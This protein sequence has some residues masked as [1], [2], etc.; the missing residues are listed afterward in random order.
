MEKTKFNGMLLLDL[1]KAFDTV[2]H[3]ILL[4]KLNQYGIRGVVNNFFESYLT[5]R[6]QGVIFHDNDLS[7]SNTHIDVP[8]GSSLG[9]LLFLLYKND[10]PNC[11]SSTL[12]LFADDTFILVKANTSIE[13]EFLLNSELAKCNCWIV[14]YELTLNAAKSSAIVIKPK[15][16]SPPVEMNLSCAAGSI[17]V[18]SS[19]KYLDVF[20]DDKLNF[21][22]RIKHL[23]KKV[24]RSVGILSKLK[25]YLPKHALFK[26][27]YM[28]VHSNL[29]H[30]LIVWGNTHPIYL[31]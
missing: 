9:P 23:E 29:L 25:N 18:V 20:I 16:H 12:R 3:K 24:S 8:Q 26:L 27:Y 2:E 5:N 14:A 22:E 19:A 17:K 31:S 4:A 7:K 6:S 11:I 21:Q 28:I 1:T 13:L 15:L 10:L 30:G